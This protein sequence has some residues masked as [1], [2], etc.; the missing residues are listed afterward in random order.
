MPQILQ[1]QLFGGRMLLSM[2]LFILNWR[3]IFF[4]FYLGRKEGRERETS[5]WKRNIEWLPSIWGR[6]GDQ[7]CNLALCPDW[8]LNPEAFSDGMMLQPSEPHRS[9]HGVPSFKW[10][11]YYSAPNHCVYVGVG[12]WSNG[13]GG[14][15]GELYLFIAMSLKWYFLHIPGDVFEVGYPLLSHIYELP[16]WNAKCT[17]FYWLGQ[18]SCI[19]CLR[20]KHSS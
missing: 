20:G 5:T 8:E 4:S 7:T 11:F 3:K 15:W 6:T 2:K 12:G 14:I 13:T 19:Q 9:G 16:D 18:H 1:F 17:G 10:T